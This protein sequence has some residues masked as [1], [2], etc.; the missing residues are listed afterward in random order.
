MHGKGFSV[1]TITDLKCLLYLFLFHL[2]IHMG[3]QVSGIYA[4]LKGLKIKLIGITVFSQ[5]SVGRKQQIHHTEKML[6]DLFY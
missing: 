2:H 3:M 6:L 5:S 1:H 4:N